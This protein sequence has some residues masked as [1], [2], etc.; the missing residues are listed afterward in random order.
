MQLT[1]LHLLVYLSSLKRF[2]ISN[3]CS[4]NQHF[5]FLFYWRYISV[6]K[7]R[8][9]LSRKNTEKTSCEEQVLFHILVF[10]EGDYTDFYHLTC[11]TLQPGGVTDI[12]KDPAASIFL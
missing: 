5:L 2:L 6:W 4:D 3:N 12:L 7:I 1:E 8:Q 11:D 9:D 10:R